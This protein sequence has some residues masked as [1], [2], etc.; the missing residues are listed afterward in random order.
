MGKRRIAVIGL[1]IIGMLTAG[2]AQ[3]RSA[4]LA[5][6]YLAMSWKEVAMRMPDEW[7]A[8]DTA[9]QV[10][11]NVLFAQQSIGGWAKNKPYH[12]P[13]TAAER[14]EIEKN[15]NGIGATIDNDATMMEMNFLAKMYR[16]HRDQRYRDAFLKGVN[17]LLSAQYANGGWPQFYPFREGEAVGYNAHITYNDNAMVNVMKL[18]RDVSRP[19]PLYASLEITPEMRQKAGKAFDKGVKC[20]LTTQIR[21]K[22]QPTVWCAQH[23][24][25][26]FAPAAARSYEL[27]SFSGAESAG[28]VLLLMD[29]PHPSKEVARAVTGAVRWFEDHKLEGIRLSPVVGP[30]GKKDRIVVK[31]GAAPPLWG[32]FYDLETEQPFFCDRD[33]IKKQT[34]AEIGHERR[35]GYSWYTVAPQKVLDSYPAW[36]QKWGVK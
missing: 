28:I 21:V 11:E 17:Y 29:M 5:G 30:D 27:P 31:D 32:R 24:E 1:L 26:T 3:D 9:R 23:D 7:Y 10:A 36:A 14:A 33:G 20:I 19:S 6:G 2:W 18:L 16:A 35:N 12:H 4:G 15:R 34:L 25:F 13:L 22:G 8:T